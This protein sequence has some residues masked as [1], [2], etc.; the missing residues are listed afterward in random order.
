M[1]KYRIV[2]FDGGG[3]RGLLTAVLLERLDERVKGWRK[4]ADL[5]AGTS[6]GGII[7]LGLA[8]GLNPTDLRSLYYDK[9]P[10][11]FKDSF[12]DDIRDLGNAI[13]AEYA[14]KNL[15]KEL[16]RVFGTTL[17]KNL[18]K[19]VL[20]PTF[21]LDNEHTNT[22]RRSWKPKFFHNFS[23]SDT[24]GNERVVDV[25]LYTSAAP[26]FFPSVDG[27]I[28]G[29]VIA[30]NP[31][32]A[33]LAQTQDKRANKKPPSVSEIVLLSIGTGSVL[34]RIKGKKHDWGFGQWAKPI[35]KLMLDGV[36]GV[37]DYQC[38]QILGER[39]HRLNYTFLPGQEIDMDEYKKRDK[40]VEIAEK[41]MNT[42][43]NNAV[44]WLKENW[45]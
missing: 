13:G 12:L 26:T 41:K 32:M 29:G 35:I 11:I 10:K 43:L 30:N 21:D 24:D 1:A 19:R 6:T 31:S 25:A 3:I 45:M 28:D 33:A 16:K 36:I 23:G 2:S 27:Y 44:D 38:K 20:I 9:S 42:Q 5:I 22:K 18:K 37:P 34:S 7:A 15:K 39:Y 8:K 17:L 4:K 14:N 40:L